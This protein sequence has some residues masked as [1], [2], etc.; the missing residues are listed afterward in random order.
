MDLQ[1]SA[2]CVLRITAKILFD[3]ILYHD[4]LS[5]MMCHD[6]FEKSRLK[7]SNSVQPTSKYI[8]LLLIYN[9]LTSIECLYLQ[10]ETQKCCVRY[11]P[12]SN[13]HTCL[14]IPI[15]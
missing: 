2:F 3:M 6:C 14:A 12:L 9:C 7:G 4:T 8:I 11:V 1:Y 5:E 10:L 13:I 15:L